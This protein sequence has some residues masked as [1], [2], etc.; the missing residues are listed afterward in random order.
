MQVYAASKLYNVWFAKQLAQLGPPQLLVNAVSPGFVPTTGL[1]RSSSFLGRM[2]MRHV[3][4]WMPFA[5]RLQ[6]GAR[7]VVEVC[8]GEVGGV[9][10]RYFAR[11]REAEAS[12]E[13]GDAGKARQ[14]M[15]VHLKA[16]KINKF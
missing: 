11:G 6:E 12:Q 4:A 16:L 9:S 5:V 2:F 7:R 10:G 15:E 13:A 8:V 1:S 14:M 3:A